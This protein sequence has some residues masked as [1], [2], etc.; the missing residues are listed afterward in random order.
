[1]IGGALLISKFLTQIS[2]NQSVAKVTAEIDRIWKEQ[3]PNLS[4]TLTLLKEKAR[5]D[6]YPTT[7]LKEL[8]AELAKIRKNLV[9]GVPTEPANAIS[10]TLDA[11]YDDLL[12][13]YAAWKGV[14]EQAAINRDWTAQ[15]PSELTP[16]LA[17]LLGEESRLSA[18]VSAHFTDKPNAPTYKWRKAMHDNLAQSL[19]ESKKLPQGTAKEWSE[20]FQLI[21]PDSPQ[22]EWVELWAQL[23]TLPIDNRV[24]KLEDV[25]K[26]LA[27]QKSAPPW[28]SH[29][30]KRKLE[31]AQALVHRAQTQAASQ[32]QPKGDSLQ[33]LDASVDAAMA[34][35][36]LHL[37]FLNQEPN[38]PKQE[39]N[40][41]LKIHS[42]D[43]KER[44]RFWIGDFQS[45][46]AQL[47]LWDPPETSKQTKTVTFRES[48]GSDNKITLEGKTLSLNFQIPKGLR[49]IAVDENQQTPTILFELRISQENSNPPEPLNFTP[50]MKSSLSLNGEVYQIP[51]LEQFIQRC[52]IVSPTPPKWS[53]FALGTASRNLSF[54]VHP[55]N[56]L[57]PMHL[58]DGVSPDVQELMKEINE[59]KTQK[60]ADDIKLQ[61][62][63]ENLIELQNSRRA[64]KE[65]DEEA[66]R[67]TISISSTETA[68]Q[69][70][71][72][73]LKSKEET[74]ARE[75]KISPALGTYALEIGGMRL[76]KIELT[77]PAPAAPD[78]K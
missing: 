54:E 45:S 64:K 67:L 14:H 74:L 76:C 55:S 19:F 49:L 42:F 25:L 77:A 16:T 21:L 46:A 32:T 51:E 26:S 17:T 43:F 35:H 56:N 28:V 75:A 20:L 23:A 61:K 59:L 11:D 1:M 60:T 30:V 6:P 50:I 66:G 47:K 58:K 31:D 68:L 78:P 52:R 65:K 27:A 44:M 36:F 8:E 7:K 12:K 41:L 37:L 63:R 2:R 71:R 34:T 9:A 48:F 39:I 29:L 53:L 72:E 10:M 18:K 73:S 69:V 5:T 22:P 38:A 40:E 33:Q 3:Q 24:K 70:T 62:Y 13:D 57:Q 15:S 4:Q